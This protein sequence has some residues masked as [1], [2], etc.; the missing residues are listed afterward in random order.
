M[1]TSQPTA[2]RHPT[3]VRWGRVASSIIVVV[4]G[5]ILV[6]ALTSP[7][8]QSLP[9]A[10]RS[11]ANSAGGWSM[12][13]FLL[14]WLSRAR[15]LPGALLGAAS[16][17]LMVESYGVVS[18]LRGHFF[19]APLA[20]PWIPI[21]LVSGPILGAGAALVRYGS[22]RL[23]ILSVAI[24]SLVM[25]AEGLYGLTLIRSTTSPVYWCIQIAAAVAFLAV[26]F[27]RAGK[28]R[29]PDEVRLTESR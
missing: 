15:P 23:A 19:A 20:S 8:Q 2:Q 24:L 6:G 27:V 16:F 9:D 17:V 13:A 21:G 11:F 4:V 5:S 26:A 1:T 22:R 3:P 10:L 18:A 28:H 29:R 25:V 12:F 7:A 14:I